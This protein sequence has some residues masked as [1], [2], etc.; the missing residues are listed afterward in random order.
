[1]HFHQFHYHQHPVRGFPKYHGILAGTETTFWDEKNTPVRRPLLLLISVCFEI[2]NNDNDGGKKHSHTSAT[3]W[4]VQEVLLLMFRDVWHV[5]ISWQKGAHAP[6]WA[7]S[8]AR[9]GSR[10]PTLSLEP[11][12]FARAQFVMFIPSNRF[13][14][15]TALGYLPL[16]LKFLVIWY[17][18]YI[19]AFPVI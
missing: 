13:I 14:K 8:R 10:H 2:T 1:M 4:R 9:F 16:V 3:E 19:R 17:R 7:P 6:P 15:K 12:S 18:L 11:T 5:S